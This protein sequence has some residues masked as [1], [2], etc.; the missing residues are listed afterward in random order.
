MAFGSLELGVGSSEL[1]ARAARTSRLPSPS[2]DL[3]IAN[4]LAIFRKWGIHTLGQ[5]AALDKE[6]LRAR[7]GAEAVR[8]WE[9]ANGTATRL[10][11]FVQPPEAFEESFEFDH[12][13]ET[14]EP[15]LFM[16]R[17]FLE[18]FALRLSSIYLVAKELTLSISF[19]NSRQVRH[20]TDSSDWRNEPA[21]VATATRTDKQSYERVFKIVFKIPQPTNDVDLLFRMLQT[22]LENFKSEHPI[23]AV[24]LTAQ[25]TRPAS[26]QFG[27]FETALRN[28]QQL[29]E[30]LARLSA[31]LGSDRVGS[32]VMEETHR[33]DSFRMEPFGW[34]QN[35]EIRMSNDEE[36]P[37][38]E[39]RYR[40]ALRRF[41]PAAAASI[42]TS[43][44]RP[45]SRPKDSHFAEVAGSPSSFYL[46]GYER[47]V[48]PFE[49]AACLTQ[50]RRHLQSDKIA[51]KVIDQ[52]GPFLFSGN[53]WDEKSWA[54]AE[55]DM[56]LDDNSLI[57]CHELPPS[58]GYGAAGEGVWKV[59]GIYD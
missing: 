9:R 33:P 48:I 2:S 13:I 40:I 7:L 27:L 24:A 43:K 51:G 56:Q 11:K 42:F 18:Q 23:V 59:D 32:P 21:A 5:L 8:L 4:I 41:R 53:W 31:L 3:Q 20:G 29:Y 25:S 10:L 45:A 1:I 16:L 37:T 49:G 35:D 50:V 47:R 55:W 36:N 44:D 19:S 28:P 38:G 22:H 26:Q 58:P 30:T 14:A 39:S 12:E 46:D 6:E 54:R 57:R 17:R 15:L 52:S 34:R